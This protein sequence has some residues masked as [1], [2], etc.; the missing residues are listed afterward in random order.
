MRM[1]DIIQKKKENK[2]LTKEEIRYFVNMFTAGKIENCKASALMM[3]VWFNGM[4]DDE[5]NELTF[6]MA[7]S[8]DSVDLS[9]INGFT[10]DKHSTGGVGDKTTLIAA[11]IVAACSGKVAK[12]SGRGLGHTGG[13]VDKLE[14][15]EGF[16]TALDAEEF[17]DCVNKTGLCIIG[18][19]GNLAPADKKMYAIRDI[20]ATVDSIPLIASSIMSKKLAAG[21]QGI[22]LDVKTGSGAFMKTVEQSELLARKMV[23]IGKAAGRKMTA[24]ITDMDVP[25]GCA[26]GNSLEVIEA[27]NV[28]NDKQHDELYEI[29]ITL[30]A[31]M[32]MFV[33]KK[34]F[35]ECRTMAE[36]AVKCGAALNKLKEMVKYQGGNP[37]WIDDVS[38]FPQAE[39][40]VPVKSENEGYISHMNAEKIGK[41]SVLL[42]AG[43]ERKEDNIDHSAGIIL[44]KKTGDLVHKEDI[45]AYLHTNSKSAVEQAEKTFSESLAFSSAKP[46]KRDIIIKTIR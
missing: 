41:A 46:E 16:R 21:S 24:V 29:C 44:L 36:N 39:Y 32:L 2:S 35:E 20:T 42:G 13:T 19:T 43:R 40:I 7:E 30:A 34:S 1:Y 22:V 12:M 28:L 15:I 33:H 23:A 6:A 4:N 9:K 11:P 8:G 38:L 10:V 31:N 27:V 17:I 25:L 26:I 37:E 3:A 14:S 18:Q 45:I 5:L